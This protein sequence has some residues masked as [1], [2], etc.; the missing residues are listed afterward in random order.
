M[1]NR[2]KKPSVRWDPNQNLLHIEFEGGIVNIHQGLYARG[3]MAD[4][5]TIEIIPDADRFSGERQ[6]YCDTTNPKHPF[7]KGR[8]VR[9]LSKQPNADPLK[10]TSK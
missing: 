2:T 6:W 9:I 3:E 1:A 8:S 4:C 10:E 7:A 5:T